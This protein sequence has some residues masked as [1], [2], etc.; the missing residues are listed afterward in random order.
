MFTYRKST[1]TSYDTSRA[2]TADDTRTSYTTNKSSTPTSNYAKEGDGAA[3]ITPV[4]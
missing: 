4:T 3:R 1:I 2:S